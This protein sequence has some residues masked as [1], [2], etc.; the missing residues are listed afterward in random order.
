[1]P[2]LW[3]KRFMALIVD[4]LIITLLLWVIAAVSTPVLAVL[5]L[6]IFFSI[7]IPIAAIAIVAYFTYFEGKYRTTPGKNLMKLKVISTKGEMDYRK[8]LI[9]NLSKFLWLP[10]VA[11]VIVG[12]AMKKPRKRYLDHLAKTD[13]VKTEE[14]EGSKTKLKQSAP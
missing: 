1:M 6:L 13:V 11:D 9:R 2:G 4:F 8:S 12:F 7:W 5:N 10:L 3:S 14:V